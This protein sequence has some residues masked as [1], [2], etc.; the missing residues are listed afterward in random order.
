MMTDDNIAEIMDLL[1]SNYG[2]KAYPI[3]E[4]KKMAKITNLWA[5][6]FADDD[7]AEV[8]V[9]VK[10]C[11]ATLQF[12]PK[13]ADIKSRIAQNRMAGQ[14][15]EMEAWAIIRDAVEQSDSLDKAKQMF[16]GFSKTIKRTVGSPSQLRAWRIV[17]DEQFETVIASN[18]QRTYRLLA[19]RE[20]AWHQLTPDVQEIESW[21]I[22]Q[23]KSAKLPAPEEPK[24][25]AYEKPDWDNQREQRIPELT[26]KHENRINAFLVPMTADEKKMIEAREEAR[27][28]RFVK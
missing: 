7:P 1:I 28:M 9:A 13:I 23:P 8:L 27:S 2:E 20:A 15:T 21:R 19:E 12:P 6:M 17:P 26:K 18:C 10:D 11:I 5:V 16:S 3:N 22:E 14:P 24:R 25:L 4:P